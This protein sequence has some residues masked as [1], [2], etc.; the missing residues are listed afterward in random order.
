MGIGEKRALKNVLAEGRAARHVDLLHQSIGQGIEKF[1]GIETV[2]AGIQ[3]EV[4]DIEEKFGARLAADQTEKCGIGHVRIRPFEQISY[5]LER[6]R[7]RDTR[8]DRAN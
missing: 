4:L 2:I 6:E 3:I 7:N 8:L 1:V 5:V